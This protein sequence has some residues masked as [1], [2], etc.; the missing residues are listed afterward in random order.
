[1]KSFK[2]TLRI[3]TGETVHLGTHSS[4]GEAK[5]AI[6]RAIESKKFVPWKEDDNSGEQVKVNADKD[7][8]D[9][10]EEK[11]KAATADEQHDANQEDE[12]KEQV[13]REK[14]RFFK[15]RGESAEKKI[16][17]LEEEVETLRMKLR[18]RN[19]FLDEVRQKYL[20]DVVLLK[21]QIFRHNDMTKVEKWTSPTK[22]LPALDS[23][24]SDLLLR[25]LPSFDLRDSMPIFENEDKLLHVKDCRL[26]GGR[27]EVYNFPQDAVKELRDAYIAL[28]KEKNKLLGEKQIANEGAM[29]LQR[30]LDRMRGAMRCAQTEASSM[31]AKMKSITAKHTSE[32]ASLMQMRHKHLLDE[33]SSVKASLVSSNER[34]K[35]M[36]CQYNSVMQDRASLTLELEK[37]NR[38]IEQR[39]ISEQHL[40]KMLEAKDLDL[41]QSEAK[42][43][44]CQ[45]RIDALRATLQTTETQYEGKIQDLNDKHE[46][47][48]QKSKSI[49]IQLQREVR[50]AK[51]A[52]LNINAALARSIA[53][54]K[55]A[56]QS[57]GT[58]RLRTVINQWLHSRLARGFNAL[59]GNFRSARAQQWKQAREEYSDRIMNLN[60]LIKQRHDD[61]Q[62][63]EASL[64]ET[65]K[66]LNEKV[67]A[68]EAKNEKEM[69]K[70]TALAKSLQ[71]ER[72]NHASTKRNLREE[73]AEKNSLYTKVG[74]LEKKI[75][76]LREKARR[77][78]EEWRHRLE[79][80]QENTQDAMRSFTA[81]GVVAEAQYSVLCSIGDG[82]L[83]QRERDNLAVSMMWRN[84]DMHSEDLRSRLH[85]YWQRLARQEMRSEDIRSALHDLTEKHKMLLMDM[86]GA[87]ATIKQ[88]RVC[89]RDLQDKLNVEMSEKRELARKLENERIGKRRAVLNNEM[90]RK[91]LETMEQQLH[92]TCAEFK[93][94]QKDAATREEVLKED[95]KKA[96]DVVDTLKSDAARLQSLCADEVCRKQKALRLCSSLCSFI[97]DGNDVDK[98][99]N[100][101]QPFRWLDTDSWEQSYS[102]LESECERGKSAVDMLREVRSH[103]KAELSSKIADIQSLEKTLDSTT[104]KLK[105]AQR[106]A[107]E[108][109]AGRIHSRIAFPE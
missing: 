79:E 43:E 83:R 46:A 69:Q 68:A 35:K 27:L 93:E 39:I 5:D 99:G 42:R 96:E 88:L 71:Q 19:Q 51:S 94:F 4:K 14:A 62:L 23:L 104:T 76:D 53:S 74:A 100:C 90:F 1:M 18:R 33:L 32:L 75:G 49:E 87:E 3:D 82:R 34:N 16:E 59:A 86:E 102:S 20:D 21:E 80:S 58:Q 60:D 78:E 45:R 2:A 17:L 31:R 103:L 91:K 70:S 30:E 107:T 64:R 66:G 54:A 22:K 106:E 10:E 92:A 89:N 56:A 15:M 36:L 52:E 38:E 73:V 7:D 105:R 55:R 24:P 65:I 11:R 108:G 25:M 57:S 50:K 85:R 12:E 13:N 63:L 28:E 29:S 81:R 77:D 44:E 48:V 101:I 109:S 6:R 84:A 37:A 95:S 61:A 98:D 40:R 67:V 41:A 97:L 72:F 9:D 26:C 47:H 8:D